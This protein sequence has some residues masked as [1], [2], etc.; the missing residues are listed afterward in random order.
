[1][2]LAS[3]TRD[4]AQAPAFAS[5]FSQNP[6]MWEICQAFHPR[7]ESVVPHST[8]LPP[9]YPQRI[10]ADY[11]AGLGILIIGGKVEISAQTDPKPE[12]ARARPFLFRRST[13]ARISTLPDALPSPPPLKGL[14]NGPRKSPIFSYL[15]Q[16]KTALPQAPADPTTCHSPPPGG[17]V[18][19]SGYG[20][21]AT[22][23]RLRARPPRISGAPRES[24][25]LVPTSPD[26][27]G[28]TP[29]H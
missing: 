15:P 3:E 20:L 19:A 4:C 10:L 1:M 8:P 13:M 27:I 28:T 7:Y 12:A 23:Y 6:K 16:S 21:Q 29:C 26:Q 9:Q 14:P 17:R 11:W 24:N 25:T 5:R 18:L 2:A 22:G